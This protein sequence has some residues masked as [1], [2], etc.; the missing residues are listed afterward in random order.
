LGEAKSAA[1]LDALLNDPANVRGGNHMNRWTYDC[2][3]TGPGTLAGRYLRKFWQPVHRAEDLKIGQAKP[4]H[5]MSEDFTVYRGQSGKCYVVAPRCAH[6]RV[7]LHIGWVEGDD[8]RCRYHGWKY[9]GQGQCVE[10]PAEKTD[11]CTKVRI[12]HKPTIEYKGLVFAYLGE[13]EPPNF[14][15]FPELDGDGV[16]E[17]IVYRRNCNLANMIDNQLDE[18]HFA[19]THRRTLDRI[20]EIPTI[21]IRRTEYG[22]ASYSDRPGRVPRVTEFMMPNILRLKIMLYVAVPLSGDGVAWRV[23]IDDAS[24]YSFG[25]NLF[26][27]A[28]TDRQRVLE[29][30]QRVNKLPVIPFLD[31][32]EDVLAGKTTI[33]EVEANLPEH[34]LLHNVHFED[35]V[36]QQAQG[37][38]ADR[39]QE[40]LASSD[41]GVRAV[42]DLWNEALTAFAKDG[43]V[44]NS[45]Q[46]PPT[47]ATTGEEKVELAS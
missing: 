34:N 14:P 32:T 43:T 37:V 4:L 6:R 45:I 7:R 27:V 13:G 28:K 39:D 21:S 31:L 20:P 44:R 9:N 12:E 22:V 36:V 16:I 30:Q 2:S 23:P 26:P 47:I 18:A 19:F 24:Q 5:I 29:E 41:I 40:I 17:A 33:E 38:I 11:F 15:M 1:S 42:R 46:P 8:I 10:Q 25:V 3:R 35:H